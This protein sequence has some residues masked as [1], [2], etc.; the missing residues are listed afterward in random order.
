MSG[1]GSKNCTVK[2]WRWRDPIRI[3]RS[4]IE[5]RGGSAKGRVS[6]DGRFKIIVQSKGVGTFIGAFEGDSGQGN[7]TWSDNGCS[8]HFVLRRR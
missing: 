1:T 7:F 6:E 3:T 8:G 4:Q 5:G 2:T